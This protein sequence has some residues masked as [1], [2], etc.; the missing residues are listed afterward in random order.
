M[1]TACGVFKLLPT[2]L[3]LDTT[4]KCGQSFR[5]RRIE[6]TTGVIFRSCLRGRL[7]TLKQADGEIKYWIQVPPGTSL[8]DD[9]QRV[10]QD[11]LNLKVNLLA[12]YKQWNDRD[13]HFSRVS[14]DFLGLRMLRQ[15]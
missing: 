13:P 4:L 11:Y 3:R 10:L 7:I 2:E 8:P 5:W 9:S 1:Q 15:V 14:P 6:Q 12:L